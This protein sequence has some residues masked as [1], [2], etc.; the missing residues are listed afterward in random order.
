D[1]KAPQAAGSATFPQEK[2]NAIESRVNQ[3]RRLIRP[4]EIKFKMPPANSGGCSNFKSSKVTPRQPR[5]SSRKQQ[6]KTKTGRV[7]S[8]ITQYLQPNVPIVHASRSP[9][10]TSG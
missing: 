5:N 2:E 1:L 4:S 7:L 10:R 6:R 9:P 8:D 3:P